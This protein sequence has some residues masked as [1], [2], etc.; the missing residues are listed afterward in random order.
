[1]DKAKDP[2]EAGYNDGAER[3]DPQDTGP[4]YLAGWTDG[5]W[6]SMPGHSDDTEPKR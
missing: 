5:R 4:R 3:K 6:D 2:Y 1:M